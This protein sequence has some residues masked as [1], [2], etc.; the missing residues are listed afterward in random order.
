MTLIELEGAL[1]LDLVIGHL[2]FKQALVAHQ[3]VRLRVESHFVSL[4]DRAFLVLS[5]LFL[6]FRRHGL[7]LS[8]LLGGA[9]AI[10]G[11]IFEISGNE[12]STWREGCHTLGG[13]V[14]FHFSLN[15]AFFEFSLV[16]DY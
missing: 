8:H 12:W 2:L 16:F 13:L 3:G 6:Y 4:V 9:L 15:F 10:F 11:G 14:H 7:R 5:H 1:R